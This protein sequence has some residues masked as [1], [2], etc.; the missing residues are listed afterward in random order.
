[1]NRKIL[2]LA[3]PSIITNITTPL[4]GLMD[5]AIVGHMGSAVYIAA[6]AVGGTMFNMLYWLFGF[7][8]MGSSGMT[9]QAYGAGDTHNIAVVLYRALLVAA[10]VGVMLVLVHY[11]V[12]VFALRFM[13]A[14]METQGFA[15]R[16]FSILVWGAPAVLGT[17]ALSG[18]FLGMQNAKAS[19]W[20]S[21]L[22]NVSNIAVSLILVLG[23]RLKI[24]GVA[25]GTLTAQWMGFVYG[26][27]VVAKK[28]AVPVPAFG[29]LVDRAGLKRFFS[30]NIDI[31]LRTLCLVA[32]TMWFT[33]VGATQ[34]TLILAVNTLLMQFFMLFSYF[35]D[36]FGF[37]G[38]AL[39]GR[40]VGARDTKMAKRSISMLMKWGAVLAVIFSLLYFAV[41]AE[42]LEILSSDR[43]VT[44][45]AR[46][47]FYW[48]VALPLLS[49]SAFSWDGIYIGATDTRAMLV[50]IAVATTV[51]FAA[52]C[53]LF[54][55]LGNHG[56][57][58]AFLA[59][60]SVRGVALS[61]MR[62]RIYRLCR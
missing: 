50:S 62:R 45:A 2:A 54:P 59:Y 41:G 57:W 3:V 21:I 6:I 10:C 46:D 35:M 58:I 42:F 28:Y 48:V 32:V 13:D 7:L 9:A 36:G 15:M 38:E 26:L 37:A 34:G 29:D 1:M 40:Y 60:L 56:L 30:V 18:W 51:Y 17:Y 39:V 61:L 53:F 14:D 43:T 47:Y 20:M 22:I 44:D 12:G 23:F 5:V 11:P 4:L 16:Y 31:F 24:E 8:R 49:F 27:C 55:L 19:M 33:R 52:Y 25:F